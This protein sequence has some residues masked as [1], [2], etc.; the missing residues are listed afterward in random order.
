MVRMHTHHLADAELDQLGRGLGDPAL[1]DRLRAGQLS[2]RMLHLRLLLDGL[3][4][5]SRVHEHFALLVAATRRRPEL[6]SAT[7]AHPH[8]GT[9]LAEQLRRLHGGRDGAPAPAD[10]DYLGCVAA[11][12]A[13]RAGLD[14]ELTLTPRD[15]ALVLPGRGMALV[16]PSAPAVVR[17]R[18]GV[19]RI[20]TLTVPAEPERDTENWLAV[21]TLRAESE[22]LGITLL[23]DDLDP[24]RDRH[25]LGAATR[26]DEKE[27][28]H[29]QTALTS[30]W[31]MLTRQHRQYAEGIAA[32]LT[33]VVP[34]DAPHSTAGVN[35][36]S[37][38]A[39]GAT[40]MTR[41]ADGIA[42]GLGL[43]H[44][45][46]HAKLGAVLDVVELYQRDERPRYYAPWRDDPRP[47]GAVLQGVYA[48]L[49]VTD[50]WRVQR[51]V[52]TGGPAQLAEAEFVRW[53]DRVWRTHDTLVRAD[54]FTAP[55]R[56]FLAAMRAVQELWWSEPTSPQAQ[57]LARDAAADHW[58]GWRLRNRRPDRA[59]VLRLADLFADGEPCPARW[60]EVRVEP[61]AERLLT[62]SARLDLIRLGLTDP[63]R[64]AELCREPD[65]GFSVGD[66]ALVGGDLAAARDAY[67]AQIAVGEDPLDAWIGLTLACQRDDRYPV[68]LDSPE[69]CLAVH[70]ELRR[71]GR[72]ADPLELARWLEPV[73]CDEDGAGERTWG[74]LVQPRRTPVA[75]TSEAAPDR[76]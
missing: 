4:E 28:R 20:G 63:A 2:K 35:V 27:V 47:L 29:W 14:F 41:P 10:V 76:S 25:Q 33:T 69:L 7:L 42:L 38:E 53:R 73:T 1:I 58:V 24:F 13:V 36:T 30:A 75:A 57:Q 21:R 17:H 19:L 61:R 67:R 15:G 64:F 62:F 16:D 48:F 34:L 56:R 23:L 22:G 45:F 40:A 12:A 60:V 3:P 11:D 74:P 39:F 72:E 43:V 44:E 50:F 31:S 66:L 37:L 5:Q 52:L 54:R 65:P 70:T 59:A 46:Q 6:G 26:L 49:A 71:R 55:G 18:D 9:W 32:G 51:A 68:R 8:L